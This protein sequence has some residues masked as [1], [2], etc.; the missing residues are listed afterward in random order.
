MAQSGRRRIRVSGEAEEEERDVSSPD[1]E[2]WFDTASPRRPQIKKHLRTSTNKHSRAQDK[3]KRIFNKFEPQ[4]E[5]KIPSA[6]STGSQPSSLSGS[7]GKRLPRKT[8][9]IHTGGESGSGT[10]GDD[11]DDD[12]EGSEEAAAVVGPNYDKAVVSLNQRVA[13]TVLSPDAVDGGGSNVG[14]SLSAGLG[15]ALANQ[16]GLLLNITADS[17]KLKRKKMRVGES[18]SGDESEDSGSESP[19]YRSSSPERLEE[20]KAVVTLPDP[21][22][23]SQNQSSVKIVSSSGPPS[24]SSGL[25]GVANVGFECEEEN[26]LHQDDEEEGDSDDVVSTDDVH[27]EE[28]ESGLEEG[29]EKDGV[30]ALDKTDAGYARL[31]RTLPQAE[32]DE[33]EEN[34]EFKAQ[35][36][37]FQR[38]SKQR[39]SRRF[40]KVQKPLIFFIH[41]VGGSADKWRG[42]I[43]YF[44][45]D[46]GYECVAPDL[47]GHG[48][49]SAPDRPKSYTFTK[50]LR[51]IVTIFDHFTS[52]SVLN[53]GLD[54]ARACVVVCH[55]YGCALGTALTRIRPESVKSLV[56]IASGGPTPLAPPPPSALP[57]HL[58]TAGV[59]GPRSG[60][61]GRCC[62][63][64]AALAIGLFNSCS[65]ANL[66]RKYSSDSKSGMSTAAASVAA[67]RSR[68]ANYLDSLDVPAYVLNHIIMGQVWPEG[69]ASYYRRILVPTLLVY[70][71]KDQ[72]V[73][74]VEMCEMERTI[75]KSYLELVPLAGH[76]V[77][78]DQ[79]KALNAM[80]SKFVQKYLSSQ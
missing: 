51:D 7:G 46:L 9:K 26:D 66:T 24:V 60:M 74:L 55:G 73:S 42:Q 58:A 61:A 39:S 62:L 77:M 59:A 15:S 50:L 35:R 75:P 38:G 57:Q 64:P 16:S 6:N 80:I 72:V 78:H 14:S 13:T 19:K 31:H 4:A 3:S 79:P 47:I 69:D 37:E 18:G 49:S 32:A 53:N 11:D 8:I 23:T 68:N 40:P 25:G 10:D 45:G 67:R 71:L 44:N 12:E 36:E 22:T 70:G 41:G 65:L 27:L 48:F 17:T 34:A 30:K 54:T 76:H 63:I 52:V 20:T 33:E 43:D 2:Y 29:E 28:N 21:T 5:R 56:M 1:E